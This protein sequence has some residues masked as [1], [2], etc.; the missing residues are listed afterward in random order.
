MP[1]PTERLGS[2]IGAHRAWRASDFARPTDLATVLTAEER[3]DLVAIA[4]DLPPDVG[5]W[6]DRPLYGISTPRL[7]TRFQ[8]LANEMGKGRGLLWIRGL[9]TEDPE[10]L[11]RM[12]WVLGNHLGEPVMQNARG[13]VLSEVYDRFAGAPRGRDSRGYESNDELNFHCDGGDMIGLACVRPSPEGGESG[14][15]SLLAVYNA[16]LEEAP[17][18]LAPLYRGFP[19]YQRK[20]KESD[21]ES[22]RS[23]SVSNGRLPVFAERGGY[24][25]AWLNRIL[26]EHACEASGAPMSPDEVVALDRLEAIANRDDMALRVQLE[27]GDVVFIHNL[28]VMHR[29]DRYDDDPDPTR[30]RLFYRMWANLRAGRELVRP[31]AGLRLG[32]RGPR[33]VIVGPRRVA[34]KRS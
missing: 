25:S 3:A 12:F 28:S 14:F 1:E 31:H 2:P 10:R 4:E 8:A 9:E 13:E 18:V 7:R 20:E 19:L 6:L 32:I 5:D 27:E 24:V 30:Q 34:K 26:A 23:A 21:G 33:P 16:L 17:E 11:R 15:V 29:R 22:E